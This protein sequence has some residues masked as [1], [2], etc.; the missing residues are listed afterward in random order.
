MFRKPYLNSQLLPTLQ[1]KGKIP[2]GLYKNYFL[3]DINKKVEELKEVSVL[4]EEDCSL[5]SLAVQLD[6]WI[7]KGT[8]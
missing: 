1:G 8:W 6:S 2:A 3:G 4:A 7:D 5:E